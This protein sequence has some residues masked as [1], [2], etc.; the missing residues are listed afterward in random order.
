MDAQPR[1]GEA[2]LAAHLGDGDVVVPVRLELSKRGP[3]AIGE[4]VVL[5]GRSRAGFLPLVVH[6]LLAPHAAEQGVQRPFLGRELGGRQ[7]LEDV[8]DVNLLALDDPQDHE[9]EEATVVA[10]NPL[11]IEWLEDYPQLGGA[12]LAVA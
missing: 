11:Y 10:R 9:F 1:V 3:A 8:G 2:S 12:Q 7:A 5:A 4:L 6:Q